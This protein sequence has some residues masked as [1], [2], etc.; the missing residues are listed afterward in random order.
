MRMVE[1]I[2][3]EISVKK[4]NIKNTYCIAQYANRNRQFVRKEGKEPEED[5][6]NGCETPHDHRNRKKNK[7][8]YSN[9]NTPTNI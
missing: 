3:C 9:M 7:W 4:N 1:R 8:V 2:A 5:Q 6:I